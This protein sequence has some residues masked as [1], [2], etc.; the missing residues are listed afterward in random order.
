MFITN[1]ILYLG[2]IRFHC[3]I[4]MYIKEKLLEVKTI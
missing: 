3:K 2:D 4:F 1:M